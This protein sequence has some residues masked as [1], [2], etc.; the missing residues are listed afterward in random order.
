MVVTILS[1]EDK[2]ALNRA[3]S[4]IGKGRIIVYP[5]DTV[6]GL[7]T[8]PRSS[9]GVSRCFSIKTRDNSKRL[10][11]LYSSLKELAEVAIIDKRAR[12]LASHFWPG[13][14]TMILPLTHDADYP[15]LLTGKDRTI[16]ARIP[17]HKCALNLIRSCGGSL[18]GTSANI[19]GNRSIVDPE[20]EE[21]A[22]IASKCD[23]FLKGK[24]GDSNL[25]STIVDL[26]TNS[27]EIRILREGAV[28]T[29]TILAYFEKQS[30]LD[31]SS[32]KSTM[33]ESGN[34]S[35]TK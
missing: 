29:E 10:P 14:L 20:D 17:G 1:C 26:A 27:S 11:V 16:A 15:E 23:Y 8:N 4:E 32:K 7:G 6:F 3:C 22:R 25:S 19:S 35:G 28:K 2:G 30:R 12:S 9:E 13:K 34:V 18:I 24:C 33:R 31:F 21:L 5:T